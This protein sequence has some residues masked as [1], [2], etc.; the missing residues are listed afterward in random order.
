MTEKLNSKSITVTIVRKEDLENHKPVCYTISDFAPYPCDICGA[1]YLKKDDL[2][3]HRT[4]YH[5]LG[6]FS[7]VLAVEIFWCD[8]CPLTYGSKDDLELHVELCHTE[9]N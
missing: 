2:G 3:R 6:T 5:D 9:S 7:D 1:Q 8:V 4:A